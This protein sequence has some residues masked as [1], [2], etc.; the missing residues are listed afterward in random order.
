MRPVAPPMTLRACAE[1]KTV[2]RKQLIRFS[3]LRLQE[4]RQ[5]AP[6]HLPPVGVLL[7]HHLEDVPLGK[8]Q[9]RLFTGNQVVRVWIIVE[10]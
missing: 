8:G 6:P 2:V 5:R 3:Q 4:H 9:S 10:V 7:V 1:V